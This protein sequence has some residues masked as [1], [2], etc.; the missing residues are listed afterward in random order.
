[1]QKQSCVKHFFNRESICQP[2]Q[3]VNYE[4]KNNRSK[5]H[6]STCAILKHYITKRKAIS[7]LYVMPNNMPKNTVF[8]CQGF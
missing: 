2:K 7:Y 8:E 4:P 5:S 6:F 1:M 3:N